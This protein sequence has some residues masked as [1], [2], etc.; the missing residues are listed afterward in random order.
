M[1]S[2]DPGPAA[3]LWSGGQASSEL[4]PPPAGRPQDHK[5]PL[6]LPAAPQRDTLAAARVSVDACTHAHTH[7]LLREWNIAVIDFLA[8][9]FFLLVLSLLHLRKISRQK[10]TNKD[11][12]S[13]HTHCLIF[14]LSLPH[15]VKRSCASSSPPCCGRCPAS[16]AGSSRTAAA[17][18]AVARWGRWRSTRATNPGGTLTGEHQIETPP[19]M[20]F[21]LVTSHTEL[22]LS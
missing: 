10:L 11:T 19:D 4:R 7:T 9:V 18:P 8:V 1:V 6:R 12:C 3:V 5:L 16:S 14:V 15:L 2:G 22:L 13:A 17:L 20:A 21:G